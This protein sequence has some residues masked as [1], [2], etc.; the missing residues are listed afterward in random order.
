MREVQVVAFGICD[1]VVYHRPSAVSTYTT[2]AYIV[3]RGEKIRMN[4][5]RFLS[6]WVLQ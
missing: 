1:S 6:G 2:L 5:H 3:G 4:A